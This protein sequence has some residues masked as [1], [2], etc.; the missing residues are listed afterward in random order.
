MLII[1]KSINNRNILFHSFRSY[2]SDF[3]ISAG[4][5]HNVLGAGHKIWYDLI[6]T[7]YI[8]NNLSQNK[9]TLQGTVGQNATWVSGEYNSTHN[10]YPI[11]PEKKI[12][13]ILHSMICGNA[14]V[15]LDIFFSSFYFSSS[16]MCFI[17]NVSLCYQKH[18]YLKLKL[19]NI[20]KYSTV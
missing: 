11:F 5:T 10:P 15:I 14:L 3:K 9:V 13:N 4:L 2:K 7:Y 1:L 19:I 16:S 18:I 12:Y 20:L 6:L 8:C 17:E